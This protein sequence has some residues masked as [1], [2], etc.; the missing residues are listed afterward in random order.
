[1]DGSGYHIPS[2]IRSGER[3]HGLATEFE[4]HVRMTDIP[5]KI[6]VVRLKSNS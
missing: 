3:D 4:V 5:P 6:F 2:L 1:M